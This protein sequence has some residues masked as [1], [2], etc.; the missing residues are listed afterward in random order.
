MLHTSFKDLDF[1]MFGVQ[2]NI[3]ILCILYIV[4]CIIYIQINVH[5]LYVPVQHCI[6]PYL[7]HFPAIVVCILIR[8]VFLN[9]DDSSSKQSKLQSKPVT[10]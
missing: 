10:A 1:F 6:L 5:F 2:N 3:Y 8:N 9:C 4:Y 7:D